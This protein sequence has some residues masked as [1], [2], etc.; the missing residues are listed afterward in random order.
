MAIPLFDREAGVISELRLDD[1]ASRIHD[2]D[3]S[4]AEAPQLHAR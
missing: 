2:E 4:G 3:R 1:T